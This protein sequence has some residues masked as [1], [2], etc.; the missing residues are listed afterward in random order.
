MNKIFIK[1]LV[2]ILAAVAMIAVGS[3]AAAAP[4]TPVTIQLI[5]V[6]DWHA[7]LDP[8]F[9]FGVGAVGGAAELSTYFQNE[10]ANNP[11]TLVL[12]AGDA[13][14]AS[15]PLANFFNEEPAVLA[16]N[17]MGFDADTF[18]NHNF[19][20]GVDHLQ[21]MVDLAEFQYVSANLKNRED[22][23]TGVK[24][25]E[26]F[27]VGGIKVAVI[28]ITNPEAPTLVAPDAFGTIEITDPARAVKKARAKARS[29]GAQVFVVIAHMGITGFDSETGE[30]FGP[31]VDFANEVKQIDVILGDHTDFEYSGIINDVLIVENRSRGRTY[32]RTEL[33]VNP[34]NSHVLDRSVEFVTP[35]SS[36]VTP[37]PNV[38]AL[39]QPFRDQLGPLLNEVVGSSDVFV[40]RSD[41]CG[42]TAGRTC[43]SLVGNITTDAIR[44]R[45]GVDFAV[46]NSGGLR[47]SLTCPTVDNPT[48]FCPAY[49]P[50]PYPITRGQVITVLPFGNEVV[51][52]TLNGAEL[53]AVLENGVS[54]MPGASG[55]F[56]QVSGLCFTY[57]IS[58][59]SGS[60]VTSAVRQAADGSCTGAVVD[61][62]SAGSYTLAIND[63]MAVGGDEYPDFSSRVTSFDLMDVVVIDYI[64]A[65]GG[66]S[67]T[68]QG[69]INC[70]TSGATA[71]PVV[72]P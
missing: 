33:V 20:R 19:D 13:Y 67:P 48:D 40:P 52:L 23:L 66:I 59:A 31:L 28:G 25:Y 64:T 71:C 46:T 55:R 57:D 16:M 41:A 24:D 32:A 69:R 10:R 35:F 30:P 51:T 38:V 1:F 62:T 14:G 37:D 7:Q 65:S 36:A 58:A 6:S 53:K 8:L 63:F 70:T 49:T 5:S 54:Q 45:Y 68:I 56:P 26:I 34:R 21:D 22:N 39:L 12:T 43:E 50:P 47:A 11:N 3:S 42:Q 61:L 44:E 72:T 27:D 29:E 2:P 60:R 15:P 18:G 17:A 4:P 9:V